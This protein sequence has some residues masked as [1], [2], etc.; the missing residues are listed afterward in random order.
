M[1]GPVLES[2]FPAA[3]P[4][5]WASDWGEDRFGIWVAFA[6][7]GI[8]QAF[9][10]IPP[11][12]FSMGSPEHEPERWNDE[13]QHEVV[14]TRGF[15]LADT[16]CTQA[17]WQ[18]VMGSNPSGF[19]GEERP[20]EN[21]SWQDAVAFIDKLNGQ[22]PELALRLPTEAEWEYAC[23]AGTAT[24]FSF[25]ETITTDQVNFNGNFPYANGQ[26][27]RYRRETVPVRDLPANDWGLYQMHGNVWEW[28]RDWYGADPSGPVVDPTG[29]ESG[30]KRVLRGGS[31]FYYGRLVRS[32]ARYMYDPSAR[33]DLIGF[34]LARGL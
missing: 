15:W 7:Q 20:V 32:A 28:C 17:L 6:H 22:R 24:P 26:K 27:G 9:R 14:L 3:F 16:A 34:R 19:R 12:K 23:R 30:Q 25:G 29:P 10:W 4:Y 1:V 33:D 2:I 8:R 18:A 31:W 11:G 13:N 21:V 5:D